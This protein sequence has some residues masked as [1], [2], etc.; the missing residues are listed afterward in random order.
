M[1]Q[2]MTFVLIS[3]EVK[4]LLRQPAFFLCLFKK[5][6]AE[7]NFRANLYIFFKTKKNKDE[8]RRVSVAEENQFIAR[9]KS[10]LQ[11]LVRKMSKKFAAQK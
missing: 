3:L 2:K 8:E 7:I 4:K 6:F 11:N 9:W 5:L 1:N 10:F